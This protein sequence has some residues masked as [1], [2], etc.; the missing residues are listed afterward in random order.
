MRRKEQL[1]RINELL[2]ACLFV[3]LLESIVEMSPQ[4]K[5]KR[6]SGNFR[7]NED[8]SSEEEVTVVADESKKQKVTLV[9]TT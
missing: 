3:C 4:F 8:V 6:R 9:N 1:R 5:R 2:L 7:K